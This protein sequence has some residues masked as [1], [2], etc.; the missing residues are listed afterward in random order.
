[1]PLLA[2]VYAPL[3]DTYY[4]RA[5]YVFACKSAG[6][7]RKEG[8]VRALRAIYRNEEREEKERRRE[9][10]EL[11]KELSKTAAPEAKIGDQLFG[12][13]SGD[14]TNPF[15]S[16]NPFGGDP[17][18]KPAVK[19]STKDTAKE[20]S[21]S[22]KDAKKPQ[23]KPASNPSAEFPSYPCFYID[24]EEEYLTPKKQMDISGLNVEM[25]EAGADDAEDAGP[26]GKAAELGKE[27]EANTD[28][29]FQRFVDIVENNPEQVVRYRRPLAPLLYS[30]SDD[31]ARQLTADPLEIP[32]GPRGS[33]TLE[34]QLMPHA[35][36]ALEG[37]DDNIA[38]GMEWG[39]IF[40]ATSDVDTLDV[41]SNGVGYLEEW[42]GVQ[43]EEVLAAPQ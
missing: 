14:T 18:A 9:Q 20:S 25:L 41:D 26:S 7:R 39:S 1:M 34:L 37:D 15:A 43:W 12:D 42:V 8:S 11:E 31:V 23:A 27:V 19:E 22:T 24:V 32:D 5:L 2:Q 30:G 16:S 35:I 10:E 36:M 38:N 3:E 40:I 4:D 6:C 33:R 21:K 13:K 28:P 17:F 29:V